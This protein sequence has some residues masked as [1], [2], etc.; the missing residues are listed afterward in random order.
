MRKINSKCKKL[1]ANR[2][3]THRVRTCGVRSLVLPFHWFFNAGR[4]AG[5]A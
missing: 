1:I 4:P 5:S 3:Y 2:E